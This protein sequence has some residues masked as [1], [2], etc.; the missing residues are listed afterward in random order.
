M[1]FPRVV[2]AV[3]IH[4]LAEELAENG[5]V[6]LRGRFTGDAGFLVAD[7]GRRLLALDLLAALGGL[8][9]LAGQQHRTYPANHV[10]R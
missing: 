8:V 1:I 6:P 4:E 5:Y 9:W 7:G 10:G 3:R 2:R